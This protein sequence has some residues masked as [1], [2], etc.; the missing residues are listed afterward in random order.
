M[1]KIAFLSIAFGLLTFTTLSGTCVAGEDTNLPVV[2]EPKNSATADLFTNLITNLRK[3]KKLVGLATMIMVDGQVE[4][5]AVDGERKK[6]S[7]VPIEIGDRWHLGSISKSVTATMIARLVESGQMQW[8]DTVGNCFPDVVMHDDWK[9]VT[10]RQLLTHT[11]GARPNFPLSVAIKWPKSDLECTEARREAVLDVIAKK[12]TYPPGEKHAYSNVGYTIAGA[13]AEKV[14]GETW[15]NLVKREVFEP[16][17]LTGAGFGPPKSSD[18]TIEQPRGHRRIFG[19]KIAMDDQDDNTPII[20]PAGTVHMTLPDLCTYAT[21]HLRGELGTGKLLTVETYK[22]LHT[23]EL[24]HYACGWVEKPP[25][26]EIPYTTYWHNG[27]NTMWYALVVFVPGKNMVVGVTSNDCDIKQA[28]SAAWKVVEASANQ[29]NTAGD[30]E[31][32]K[33]LPSKA[34]PKKSPF[35]AVR[36]QDSLPEVRVGEEWFQFVSLDGI[37]AED[38][39]TFSKRFSEE[40]WQKRFEEDLVEVLVRMGHVPKD[41]V[42]LVVRRLSSSETQT[43]EEVPMTEENLRAIKAAGINP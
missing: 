25:T 39:V 43:F 30:A 16:L 28:E 7:G 36:W 3:E 14:T 6:G 19:L 24:N 42:R 4:A 8:S 40:E 21:E 15:E 31:L 32:R 38:I 5:V 34:F 9:T 35:A 23:P 10:M 2:D 27:S 37:T 22:Q 17:V 20:G 11:A 26:Y 29:F 18:Q 41:S 33:I 12:P 13:M 1:V